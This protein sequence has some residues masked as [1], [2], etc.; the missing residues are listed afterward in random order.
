[1]QANIH[2]KKTSPVDWHS[3]Y[4]VAA[5]KVAGTSLRKLS[6]A[7]GY[8]SKTLN[9]VLHRP[10]PKGERIVAAVLKMHPKEIWGTRYDEH[11]N[12]LS[13]KG[14]RKA[15]GQGRHARNANSTTQQN[16][17]NVEILPPAEHQE[18]RSITR[19]SGKDRRAA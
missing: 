15:I 9:N 13:G 3:A 18:C 6:I 8:H 5:L 16:G 19:R 1:M 2:P 10:W 12:P 7:H 14:A 11:G 17:C 4:I